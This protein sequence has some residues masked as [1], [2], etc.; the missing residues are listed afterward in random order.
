M[1]EIAA[2]PPMLVDGVVPG[3]NFTS[4]LSVVIDASP[5]TVWGA[6]GEAVQTIRPRGLFS[7]MMRLAA[8]MRRDS[9]GGYGDVGTIWIEK[10]DEGREVV[11]HGQHRYADY[12]TNLYLEA[13]E[14][15]RT[16]AYNVTNAKF[17]TSPP[18]KLYL[19]GVR[20]FHDPMVE[21]GLRALKRFIETHQGPAPALGRTME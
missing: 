5:E 7:L 2:K 14:D 13:L 1:G 10:M 6:L 16:L 3:A 20:I 18:G 11:V 17:V 8:L 4:T 21:W 15:G 19:K 9:F 12:V